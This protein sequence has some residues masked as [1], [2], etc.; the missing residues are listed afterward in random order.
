[1]VAVPEIDVPPEPVGAPRVAQI[2]RLVYR[3]LGS[4]NVISTRAILLLHMQFIFDFYLPTRLFIADIWIRHDSLLFSRF[5]FPGL[6]H[7]RSHSDYILRQVYR[8][9]PCFSV[10]LHNVE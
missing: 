6:D 2:M 1:M 7:V 8:A 4:K 5:G 10:R 3:N 9:P